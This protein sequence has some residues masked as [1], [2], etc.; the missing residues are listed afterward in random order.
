[1]ADPAKP[2]LELG[3]VAFLRVVDVTNIGAFFDWGLPKDLLVPFAEQTHDVFIGER[4]PIAL[5]MDDT[6][7]Y[8]GTMRV[9]EY[10]R[11]ILDV[12]QGTWVEGEAWRMDPE[13]GLFVI[14]EKRGVGLVP[15]HEPHRLSRGQAARFRVTNVHADGR[16]ELSLRAPA[17]EERDA[18]A[19][20]ILAHLSTPGAVRIGNPSTPEVILST[21]GMSKKAFKRAV[22]GLLK[23]GAVE[24]DEE[25]WLSASRPRR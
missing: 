6:N 18:D 2:K 14:V 19:A 3:E 15:T 5:Y 7:R 17:H 8:A 16:F 12:E 4:H 10:L 11:G 1:V 13:I 9:S 21:F 20:K 23:S 25:G 24:L 22:G